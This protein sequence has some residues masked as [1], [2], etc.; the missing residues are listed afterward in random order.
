MVEMR[1]I[2]LDKIIVKNNKTKTMAKIGLT[3]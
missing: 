2:K 3:T 1:N